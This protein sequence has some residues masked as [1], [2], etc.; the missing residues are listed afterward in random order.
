MITISDVWVKAARSVILCCALA[1]LQT[2]A[3]GET[4]H[5]ATG[6]Y[7]PWTSETLKHGGFT[8]QVVREA[9]RLEGYDVEFAYLPWKRAYETA[10]SGDKYQVTSYWYRSEERARDFHYSDPIQTDAVVFFHL[11]DNPPPEWE[12][13]AD[14]K[15]VR[16]G[17]TSGFTYTQEFWEL[18]KSGQLD[19]QEAESEEL[20]FKKLLKGRIDL[21]PSDSLVGQKTLQEFFGKREAA[22]VTHHPR[23]M[24]GRTGH[25]LVS[26]KASNGGELLA[27][28][29]RGLAKLRDSGRYALMQ[30]NLIAGDFDQ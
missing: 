21:F 27:A 20:N 17:A 3:A 1:W 13:L 5:I 12:T 9:F 16:I 14:L 26:K 6:E 19:V 23:P 7:A 11:K 29:N 30:A 24:S 8:N 22:K 2:V 25:L 18:A 15:G 10:N 28:F 4:V